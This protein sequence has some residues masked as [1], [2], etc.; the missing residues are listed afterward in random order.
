VIRSEKSSR[1]DYFG[2]QAICVAMRSEIVVRLMPDVVQQL[3]MKPVKV[4]FSE[5]IC[6]C[7]LW[8]KVIGLFCFLEF[9]HSPSPSEWKGLMSL[10]L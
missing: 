1:Q 6:V 10:V 7:G 4:H 2:F 9:S 8:G 3:I 5:I